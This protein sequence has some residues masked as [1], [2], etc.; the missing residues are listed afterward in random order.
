MI[1]ALLYGISRQSQK[2]AEK[3]GSPQ[4]VGRCGDRNEPVP[5][6]RDLQCGALLIAWEKRL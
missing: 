1:A 5:T 2:I 4:A 3:K 6:R